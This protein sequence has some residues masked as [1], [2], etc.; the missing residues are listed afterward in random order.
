MQALKVLH[1]LLQN[2]CPDMHQTRRHALEATVQAGLVG[3]RLTV[4]DLGRSLDSPSSHKHQIKR[5]D[6]LLS[7]THL[8]QETRE[9]YR[10]LCHQLIGS[11]TRVTLLIDWSDMDAYKRHF[12]L[13]ASL[14]LEGRSLTVYEEVHTIHTKEKLQTH[15]RFLEQLSLIIPAGCRPILVS[16]AGFRTTW[17]KL[18]ESLDWDWVGRVRNRHYM[19]WTSGGHWFDAKRCYQRATSRPA[20]LGE[21]ILTIRNHIT[22]QFVIYQGKLKGRQHKTRFGDR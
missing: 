4:T 1:K 10:L 14:M 9:I 18:V 15:A 21:G 11:R 5:V 17:F 16:D 2:T 19:R 20:H 7:N 12:L 22:C 8:H 6:R 13:R 3:R